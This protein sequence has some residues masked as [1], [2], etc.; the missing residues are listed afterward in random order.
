MWDTFGYA[1]FHVT[2]KCF[3]IYM[4]FPFVS[5]GRRVKAAKFVLCKVSDIDVGQ[6]VPLYPRAPP[7]VSLRSYFEEIAADKASFC[8]RLADG[9]VKFKE[10][11]YGIAYRT[12]I[13]E[14]STLF[15]QLGCSRR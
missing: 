2:K 11:N 15:S 6:P 5:G 7:Q 12:C 10:P 13:E 4:S 14:N 1:A 3:I 9:E 8:W